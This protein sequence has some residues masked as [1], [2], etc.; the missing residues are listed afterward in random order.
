MPPLVEP[1]FIFNF[2]PSMPLST[3]SSPGP[4]RNPSIS[5]PGDTVDPASLNVTP[6]H[7][8]SPG[9]N[10]YVAFFLREVPAL[11]PFT[12]LFPS[13]CSDILAL[14]LENIPLF[15][16]I[17]A[18]S[19]YLSDHRADIPPVTGLLHLQKT[20]S[21]VNEAISL[22]IVDEGLI[23]SVFLLALLSTLSADYK[24]SRRH[25]EGFSH[26]I[27][28]YQ[29][30]RTLRVTSGTSTSSADSYALVMLLWRMAIRMEY[31]VAFYDHGQ[32]PPIFPINDTS[33]ERTQIEWI[34]KIISK[35]IPNG[36]DWALA[37]FALDDLMNRAGHLSHRLN[38]D[39]VHMI[40]R[41]LQVHDLIEEHQNWKRRPIINQFM[42]ETLSLPPDNTINPSLMHSTAP[43]FLHYPSVR[44]SNNLFAALLIRHFM[45]GIY[46]SLIGDPRPGP[47][48]RTRF[49]YAID[50][51][52]YFVTLYG[53]PP[54][55]RNDMV[56]RPVDNCMAIITAGFTF[57]EDAYPQEFEYCT[58]TLAAI[59]QETGFASLMDVV[60][61]LK[62][63]HRKQGGQ[64]DWAREFQ[65][66]IESPSP[67]S[68]WAVPAPNIGPYV[69]PVSNL[70][71]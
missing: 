57:Q 50:I 36:I 4:S 46:L 61:I 54:L 28:I 23:A 12:E 64:A 16:A 25:L 15:Q 60:E 47:V 53:D 35:S 66:K 56:L 44:I 9:E 24:G 65:L 21:R 51:C 13:V 49:Q 48:S 19:S 67:G 52:R 40:N 7:S 14:S 11:L 37:S 58:R 59:A 55:H 5:I 34:S 29:Q 17:L 22:G 2:D 27:Q 10:I 1:F 69:D 41:S 45:I 8:T 30:G 33:Q 62:A 39:G 32:G 6:Q 68:R 42:I 3:S 71:Q 70:V 38:G 26:L 43:S 63:T 31:H 18:I 20:L